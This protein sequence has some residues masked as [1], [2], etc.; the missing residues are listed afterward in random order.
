MGMKSKRVIVL[1]STGQ[2]GT[3]LVKVLGMDSETVVLPLNHVDCDCADE[4]EVRHVI[5]KLRPDVVINCAAYVRVDDCEMHAREA[6]EI[7]AAGALNVARAC[8]A[9]EAL[10]VYISTDY[11]FDGGK[12]A[13]YVE[14]DETCP[15]NVYGTSKLAGEHLVRQT[16]PRW[17]IIRTASLF[18]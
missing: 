15:I 2:L 1:G 8:A 9:V 5:E 17:L 7:N 18:G 6:F 16:A 14:S 10:C 12:E 3:D 11:V 13:A 4:T